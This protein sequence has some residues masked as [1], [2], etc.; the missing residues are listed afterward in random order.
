MINGRQMTI[1]FHVDDCKI[2]HVE[3]TAV[4]KMIEWLKEYY[5]KWWEDGTGKMK[6]SRGKIH[7]YLGMTLDYSVAGQVSITM[8][9]Y[10]ED[11]LDA[12]KAVDPSSILRK[13]STAPE[14][15]FKIDESCEKLNLPMATSFH[16]LVAKTLFATKRVRPDTC[17]AIAFLSTRVKEPDT[18]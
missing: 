12:F 3:S 13:S 2:S 5:E 6:V 1:C 17:T 15:L 16:N 11:I 9:P 7:K 10:I 4:G 8:I 18:R 14:Y